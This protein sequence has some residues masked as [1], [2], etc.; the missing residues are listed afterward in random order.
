[1]DTGG[2]RPACDPNKDPKDDPCVIDDAQG[3]FVSGPT[4]LD[5]NAGTKAAPVKTITKG[6][7]LAKGASPK[8][9]YICAATYLEQVSLVGADGVGLFAASR[10]PAR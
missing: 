6:I 9:V 7:A 8:R 2:E 1:V 4:G 10:A 5:T 3:I